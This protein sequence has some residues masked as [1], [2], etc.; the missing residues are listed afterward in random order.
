MPNGFLHD[1]DGDKSS[2]RLLGV[3]LLGVGIIM[4]STLFIFG[5]MRHVG[6]PATCLSVLQY[7]FMAG[8]SLLGLG[9]AENF[10]FRNKDKTG[11]D[12]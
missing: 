12:R 1:S 7:T 10:T 11:D 5:L 6:D 2:K 4:A 3:V 8:T 9:I